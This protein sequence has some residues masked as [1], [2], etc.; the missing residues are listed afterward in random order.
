MSIQCS[1]GLAKTYECRLPLP[2]TEADDPEDRVLMI[3]ELENCSMLSAQKIGEWTRRDPVM[4]H[5][6]EYLLCRW[7]QLCCLSGEER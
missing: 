4:A 5:V 2:D 7:H 3:E 6:H 1:T